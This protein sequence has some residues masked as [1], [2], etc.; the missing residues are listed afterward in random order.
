MA[1]GELASILVRLTADASDFLEKMNQANT[2]LKDFAV[3]AAGLAAAGTVIGTAL[4]AATEYAS[5]YETGIFN[6]SQ[7]TGIATETISALSL[8]AEAQGKTLESVEVAFRKLGLEAGNAALGQKK[9]VEVF[10]A[11]KVSV[12]D[13]S[14]R[15]KE[16]NDLFPEVSNALSK[17]GDSTK[18]VA[19]SNDLYGRSSLTLLPVLGGG[20]DK[21]NQFAEVATR[22]GVMVTEAQAEQ[23]KAFQLTQLMAE[24]AFKGL[25]IAVGTQLMPALADFARGLESDVEAMTKLVSAHPILVD[26]VANLAIG[27]AGT[28]GLLLAISGVAAAFNYLT[29]T[30]A[31]AGGGFVAIGGMFAI[32]GS[33]AY[34]FRY[35]LAEI[36]TLIGSKLA[37]A[38]SVVAGP[39][40]TLAGKAGFGGLRDTLMD[41][42][43]S[44][45]ENSKNWMDQSI[46][47]SHTVE[48]V[49]PLDAALKTLMMSLKGIGDGH[50]DGTGK[51]TEFQKAVDRL[52][53]SVTGEIKKGPELVAALEQME[54]A[55]VDDGLI[56]DK[57]GPKIIAYTDEMLRQGKT[58]DA[59]T[60]YYRDLTIQR[61]VDTSSA[62]RQ[63]DTSGKLGEAYKNQVFQMRDYIQQYQIGHLELETVDKNYENAMK[64]SIA[65]AADFLKATHKDELKDKIDLINQTISADDTYAHKL[66]DL[67][68][69][70][71]DMKK[72]EQT[73]YSEFVFANEF[74]ITMSENGANAEQLKALQEALDE[75]KITWQ[76]YSDEVRKLTGETTKELERYWA[77]FYTSQDQAQQKMEFDMAA[78]LGNITSKFTSAFNDII[79]SGEKWVD[80]VGKVVNHAGQHLQTFA[81]KFHDAMVGLFQSTAKEM[82]KAF[83]D[84]LLNPLTNSLKLLGK[85]I[86]DTLSSAVGG[87]GGVGGG[88][89]A[90]LSGLG[91]AVPIIG[92]AIALGGLLGKLLG[93]GQSDYEKW[94]S[95][96][97]SA[98]WQVTSQGV[99]QKLNSSGQYYDKEFYLGSYAEGANYIPMDGLAFLHQGEAVIPAGMNGW[100]QNQNI[101][102][103]YVQSAQFQTV[104]FQPPQDTS[105]QKILANIALALEKGAVIMLDGVKVGNML[106]GISRDGGIQ[107]TG[108]R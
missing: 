101:A 80:D 32:L 96:E 22:T 3:G 102:Q 84:G 10:D 15:L 50:Y 95:K 9:A 89:L 29:T 106:Y 25:A 34:T 37:G 72:H 70:T 79:F 103:P 40:A 35:D 46:Q 82:M 47:F 57:L 28:G 93:G 76:K 16:L 30:F 5:K 55:H 48:A 24:N 19:L 52:V 2:G 86:A 31:A 17:V 20:I 64:A 77:H 44:L 42:K 38:L 45:E 61:N 90:G 26:A 71:A 74:L 13:S 65:A 69:A 85:N 1:S 94:V 43:F 18:A 98:G 63:F 59:V 4:T 21:L 60:Q 99:A 8:A 104:P 56:V 105:S 36:I 54:N 7:R 92:G 49:N 66:R 41:M 39:L 51:V 91:A 83:E 108:V 14:G 67:T 12:K 53:D 6:L 100:V 68:V 23:G 11:L 33:I 75:K 62:E 73:A 78:S 88:L 97:Q 58:L 27:L 81:E 107:L 87:G